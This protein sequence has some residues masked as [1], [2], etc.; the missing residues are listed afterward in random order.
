MADALVSIQIIPR[1]R[2]EK[3]TY[4]LVDEAIQV[5]ADSKVKYEVHPLETT[6]EGDLREL[7]D[8]VDRMHRKMIEKGCPSV[9]S[10]VKIFY[11]PGGASMDELTAKYR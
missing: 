2:N 10:E 4:S 1:T 5:I 11:K 3:D 6:M 7:L 9:L 8:I